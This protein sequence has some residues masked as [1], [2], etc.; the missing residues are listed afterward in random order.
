MSKTIDILCKSYVKDFWLLQL[1]LETIKKNVTGYENIIL[2]IPENDKHE[3]D[4]RFLPPRTL[5]HYIPEY[6]NGWIY[7]QWCKLNAAKYCF[8]DYIMFTDSDCFFD[9][10][11]NLHDFIAD[12]KPEILYTDW[13]KVGDAIAW[14]VPTEK[15]MGEPVA[16]EFM[17]RNCLIYH[18]ETL[19][20]INEW[21]P[22]LEKIIM[23]SERFSEFNLLGAWAYKNEWDKYNFINT[24]DWQYVPAKATQ[25]W[26]HS[27]KE[28]GADELHLR[29][30]I[31]LL[32]SL[33]KSFGINVP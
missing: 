6:G 25:C 21:Q 18:R 3:F 19:V 5:I 10:P 24:D 27:S 11:I 29:E 13:Q 28:A 30:F 33:L 14:K 15:I 9:H 8:S 2:L 31:R 16:W 17:R 26:S 23:G 7:Q 32:E 22:N 20:K 4:T 12:N 1:A